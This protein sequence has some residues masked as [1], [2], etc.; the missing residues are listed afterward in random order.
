MKEQRER[1][2]TASKGKFKGGLEGQTL[3]HRKL[4]TATHLMNAALHNMFEGQIAQR[5]QISIQI[6]YDL[7]L[8]LTVS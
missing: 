6:V 1:S 7:I 4:H 3:E 2:Q 8:H 5:V